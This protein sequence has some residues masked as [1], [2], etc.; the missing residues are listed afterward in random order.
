MDAVDLG[1]G[2]ACASQ[3]W[4]GKIQETAAADEVQ[5]AEA[6]LF[7]GGSR[8]EDGRVAGGLVQNLVR[9]GAS[10]GGQIFARLLCRRSSPR[11]ESNNCCQPERQSAHGW[12]RGKGEWRGGE[13]G[14]PPD[15]PIAARVRA[16]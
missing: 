10:I 16:I 2:A 13:G 8:E 1:C 9:G 4:E 7:T 11:G 5:G 3:I 12:V 14:Q 6:V 15:A